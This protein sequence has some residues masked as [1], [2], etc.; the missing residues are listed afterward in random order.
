MN[1]SLKNE[2]FTKRA[3]YTKIEYDYARDANILH[4]LQEKGHPFETEGCRYFRSKIYSSLVIRKDGLWSWNKYDL[5]GRSPVTLLRQMLQVDGWEKKEAYV[6]AVKELAAF[7]GYQEA[8]DSGYR[9]N[10]NRNKQEPIVE[11]K[12][13]KKLQ[14]PEKN[15]DFKR[16]I[17]Y[18][19]QTRK[20]DYDIV[21]KL[22]SEK[23]IIQEAQT[24]NVGFIA[25]DEEKNPR[26]IFLRGTVS[27]KS[28]KKDAQGSDKTYPFTFGGDEQAYRVYVFEAAIDALSH[29]TY[30]KQCGDN[31]EKDFRI[32]LNGISSEGLEYFLN[33]HQN[34]KEIVVCTDNDAAG[35]KCAKR[36]LETY[37]D[38]NYQIMRQIPPEGKDWNEFLVHN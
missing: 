9:I 2:L 33:L 30:M 34:I 31:Y 7:A 16:A 19:C 4:Y 29:A 27:N 1:E 10:T 26:H 5:N 38:T 12:Q 37:G 21:K 23:K 32:T 8:I 14:M 11:I 28:F 6:Q 15:K 13:D 20:I 17:A 35:E 25:Y 3:Y 22:I 36:I 18:L 24:N